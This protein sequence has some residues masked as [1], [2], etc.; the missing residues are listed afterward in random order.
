MPAATWRPSSSLAISWSLNEAF[1]PAFGNSV[2]QNGSDG[3]ANYIANPA[4]GPG[5]IGYVEYAYVKQ[6]KMNYALMQNAAGQFVAPD[7][8][9]FKAAAASADWARSFYQ[10]L[11]NQQGAEAWPITG[12]TFILMHKAQEKPASAAGVLKFFDWAYAN[13]DKMADDLEYVPLPPGVKDLV[14]KSWAASIKDTAGKP[15]AWK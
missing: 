1:W 4:T 5:T 12:A 2:G 9:A 14:R 15:I 10:I 7:D 11:T 13:G 6:N 3:V 8:K